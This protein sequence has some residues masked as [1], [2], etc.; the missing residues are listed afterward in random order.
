MVDRLCVQ[1]Q[2]AVNALKVGNSAAS[3]DDLGQAE[4][5]IR[6]ADNSKQVRI[7]TGVH[8]LFME[9][10]WFLL[11]ECCSLLLGRLTTLYIK[12]YSLVHAGLF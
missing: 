6:D 12:K 7:M 3:Q 5:V 8:A 4:K 10:D 1:V 9:S 2:D 11:I